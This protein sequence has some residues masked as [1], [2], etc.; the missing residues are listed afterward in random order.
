MKPAEH[1]FT[2]Q[3]VLICKSTS[4]YTETQNY[5]NIR[6]TNTDVF[7]NKISIVIVET[8]LKLAL[9]AFIEI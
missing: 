2:Y 6:D 9:L 7:A 3:L 5:I 4:I 1:I 8:G